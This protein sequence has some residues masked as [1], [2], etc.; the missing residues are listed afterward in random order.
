[1]PAQGSADM[2]CATWQFSLA[3]SGGAADETQDRLVWI[4]WRDT[5][6]SLRLP[7]NACNT[8]L[9]ARL[10]D[11]EI[12]ELPGEFLDAAMEAMARDI[13]TVLGMGEQA[14]GIRI[15]PVGPRTARASRV[16]VW[17]L[18]L[19]EPRAMRT[20]VAE[21]AAEDAA[22]QP[23]ADLLRRLPVRPAVECPDHIP[24]TVR[25]R[26]GAAEIS[27]LTLATIAP[28]DI[29]LFNP[30]LIAPDGGVWLTTPDGQGLGVR[31]CPGSGLSRYVVT[32][33]WSLLMMDDTLRDDDTAGDA[34]TGM[35]P[36]EIGATE[37][38]S[39]VDWYPDADASVSSE[40]AATARSGE[41][42]G[43]LD[44]D[45]VPVRLSFDLG[46]QALKLGE[47]RRLRPG[48]IFDLQ[49]RLD[50]GPLYVRANGALIGTAE[51]VDIDGRVGARIHTLDLD[52]PASCR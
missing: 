11:L 19:R 29:L 4:D 22:L 8:W 3:P 31:A 43:G 42:A 26:A 32:H 1:L 9:A 48:E 30:S 28:G 21:L 45:R 44:V 39:D 17:R 20:I 14:T 50:A 18:T 24:I 5:S 13:L 35:P 6:L 38:A 23:L 37:E 41:E 52:R 25:A 2:P 47:L 36:M 12:G 46:E 49:R 10:P 34:C 7:A 33:E 27:A 51:L 40:P 15:M 16:H